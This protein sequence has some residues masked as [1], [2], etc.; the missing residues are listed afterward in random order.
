MSGHV[1]RQLRNRDG[2]DDLAVAMI[3]EDEGLVGNDLGMVPVVIL[4]STETGKRLWSWA[5]REGKKLPFSPAAF[6]QPAGIR[7]TR[8]NTYTQAA[9]NLQIAPI[10]KDHC[11]V[12]VGGFGVILAEQ[13]LFKLDVAEIVAP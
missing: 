8:L 9:Q 5:Q 3:I 2:K 11:I 6:G 10:P 12:A 4:E 1:I 13:D 7:A